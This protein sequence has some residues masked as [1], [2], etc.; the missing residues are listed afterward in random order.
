MLKV[1]LLRNDVVLAAPGLRPW[2][3]RRLARPTPPGD[4]V[5]AQGHL[6]ERLPLW[7]LFGRGPVRGRPCTTQPA[8]RLVG[9][10]PRPRALL[11]RGVCTE[12]ALPFRRRVPVRPCPKAAAELRREA[13]S[14][15]A[16]LQAKP[17]YE[18]AR[19]AFLAHGGR[20]ARGVFL[21]LAPGPHGPLARV[22]TKD[23]S[24]EVLPLAG[25]LHA[26]GSVDVPGA[27][28]RWLWWA[29]YRGDV[30]RLTRPP[31]GGGPTWWDHAD[32]GLAA[33]AWVDGKGTV[34]QRRPRRAAAPLS[35]PSRQPPL[36]PEVGERDGVGATAR[37]A[38][39]P[40]RSRERAQG[41]RAAAKATAAEPPLP[42]AGEG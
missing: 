42:L 31:V 37:T 12:F 25:E 32:L 14:V 18:A 28:P 16:T 36:P 1:P 5:A 15:V 26:G 3:G 23:G 22:Q 6:A 9:R 4:L 24:V 13:G 30:Y 11:L 35:P 2:A 8:T 38:V 29:D 27:L 7:V 34:V 39:A 19:R 33:R 41:T 10:P 40:T 20:Q 17:L 21:T